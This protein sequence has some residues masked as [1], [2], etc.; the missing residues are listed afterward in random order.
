MVRI[1]GVAPWVA[2]AN[3]QFGKN[4]LIIHLQGDQI[5]LTTVM[6]LVEYL[7]YPGKRS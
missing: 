7:K 5:S 6:I 2:K 3:A 1:L 4:F